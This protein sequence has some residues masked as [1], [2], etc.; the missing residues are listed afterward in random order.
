[1]AATVRLSA[2]TR[3]QNSPPVNTPLANQL[4]SRGLPCSPRGG[5]INKFIR[6]REGDGAALPRPTPLLGPDETAI[7]S[8]PRGAIV[9]T[10]GGWMEQHREL[11][12]D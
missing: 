4:R 7:S 12:G 5:E 8:V 3:Y 2:G 10:V 9:F 6:E 11:G 1:M